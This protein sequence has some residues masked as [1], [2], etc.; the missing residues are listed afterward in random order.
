MG[1]GATSSRPTENLCP[2][3]SRG[4]WGW[5]LAVI[6]PR[7]V[8]GGLRPRRWAALL[9]LLSLALPALLCACPGLGLT[10]TAGLSL[11]LDSWFLF[12]HVSLVFPV[13]NV[14]RNTP[15]QWGIFFLWT[16]AAVRKWKKTKPALHISTCFFLFHLKKTVN[17]KIRS[18]A[19]QRAEV[20]ARRGA[21]SCW[22]RLQHPDPRRTLGTHSGHPVPFA[23]V[24][25]CPSGTCPVTAQN[26]QKSSSRLSEDLRVF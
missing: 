12:S 7:L 24:T 17:A 18:A 22:E 9:G 8:L 13:G 25:Y 14:S 21:G 26:A 20:W 10:G 16:A 6:T 19:W 2:C 1:W 15:Y 4:P 11:V 3:R 23:W 5:T